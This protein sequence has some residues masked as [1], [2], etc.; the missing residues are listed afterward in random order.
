LSYPFKQGAEMAAQTIYF[1]WQNEVL[2]NTIYPRRELKLCDVLEFDMEIQL[3]DAYKKYKDVQ[4]LGQVQELSEIISQYHTK[5]ADVI[6][7]AVGALDDL[8][9]YF[10]Q[11]DLTAFYKQKFPDIDTLAALDDKK[12]AKA[13]VNA[14]LGSING[15]HAAFRT[16]YFAN[17]DKNTGDEADTSKFSNAKNESNFIS[18]QLAA[19]DQKRKDLGFQVWTQINRVAAI[20]QNNPN[21][22]NLPDEEKLLWALQNLV[23]PMLSEERSHLI[24]LT[25]A[26]DKLVNRKLEYA[27]SAAAAVNKENAINNSLAPLQRQIAQLEPQMTEIMGDL[28]RFRTPPLPDPVKQYFSNVDVTQAMRNLFQQADPKLLDTLNG[29]HKQAADIFINTKDD[30]V[31]LV[32]LKPVLASLQ[33]YARKVTGGEPDPLSLFG[34]EIEKFKDL[35]FVLDNLN[36]PQ[37]ELDALIKAKEAELAKVQQPLTNLKKDAAGFQSQIDALDDILRVTEEKYI[38][39]YIPATPKLKEIIAQ[40]MDD[41]RASLLGKDQYELLKMIF[42]VFTKHP[43]RYPRWLQYMIVHFSGMRYSSAHGSWADPRYLFMRINNPAVTDTQALQNL[44][45]ETEKQMTSDQALAKIWDMK[46]KFPHW[47]WKEISAVTNLRL[48]EVQDESWG[49][50]TVDEQHEK[51]LFQ[52]ANY[53]QIINDWKAYYLTDWR[54]EHDRSHRLI[55]SRAVCNEVA[56]HIQHLRGHHGAAGLAGKPDLY[57]GAENRYKALSDPKPVEA[58]YLKW[59]RSYDDFKVGASILWLRYKQDPPGEWEA[60][61]DMTIS[62]DERLVPGKYLNAANGAWTYRSGGLTRTNAAT[63]HQ[64]YLFWIHEAI[65]ACKAETVEGNIVYTFE[66]ALPYDDPRMAAVGMFKRS[67]Y[68]LLYDGGEDAYNGGVTGYMPENKDGLPETDMEKLNKNELDSLEKDFD[69]M[70]NWDHV[71]LKA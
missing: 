5:R 23:Q 37:A 22:P 33:I 67:D 3:W 15:I 42:D 69:E 43:E 41:F 6:K 49:H 16:Y 31:K 27:A 11:P 60:A 55:V 65:V 13:A 29:F 44:L 47:M 30:R 58:P 53:R 51:N 50:L 71:L 1:Q 34:T 36:R 40:Q 10:K 4:D 68:N 38:S 7:Q 56:E 63:R 35:L 64:E 66:T 9:L 57:R 46:D 25:S 2:K 54:A 28:Q 52:W 19:W 21:H 39:T 26:H 18:Q 17:P 12:P 14:M 8:D 20:R 62:E 45:A 48:T 61:K 70:L 24:D 32:T 59:P